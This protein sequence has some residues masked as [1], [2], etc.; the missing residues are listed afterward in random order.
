MAD[1]KTAH[2]FQWVALDEN[3][4]LPNDCHLWSD[5]ESDRLISGRIGERI[6]LTIQTEFN[7]L[8]RVGGITT[9]SPGLISIIEVA[10]LAVNIQSDAF[11]FEH[12]QVGLSIQMLDCICIIRIR[13]DEGIFNKAINEI[14][15]TRKFS[16]SN[17]IIVF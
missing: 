6:H 17:H 16:G 4:E 15:T 5:G 1:N 2:R 14:Y 12:V 7:S 9:E 13:L 11:V 3:L 10:N 8:K